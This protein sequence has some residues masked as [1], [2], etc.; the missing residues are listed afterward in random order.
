MKSGNFLR[1]GVGMIAVLAATGYTQIASAADLSR[2]PSSQA[3]VK[4]DVPIL[5]YTYQAAGASAGSLGAQAYGLGVGASGGVGI[6]GPKQG[7]VGGGV[8][9]WGSPLD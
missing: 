2:E 3:D 8:T 5:T 1:R 9:V 7:I 4:S 6:N